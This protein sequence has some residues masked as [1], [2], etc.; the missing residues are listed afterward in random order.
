[1]A[2]CVGEDIDGGARK[3]D[4]E[5]MVDGCDALLWTVP[6]SLDV[7]VLQLALEVVRV[8]CDR[9]LLDLCKMKHVYL[10]ILFIYLFIYSFS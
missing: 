5:G 6:A 1:M 10:F 8:L 2:P 4:V 7:E 9:D 3:T